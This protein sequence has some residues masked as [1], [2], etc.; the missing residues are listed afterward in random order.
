MR[1]LDEAQLERL[2]NAAKGLGM[3]VLVEVHTEKDLKKVL[4]LPVEII[5]INNRNLNTLK[6]DIRKV[7]KLIPFIPKQMTTVCESGVSSLKDIL[8][9]KGLG[10]NAVLI[11]EAIMKEADVV[12]KMEELNIDG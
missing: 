11:G 9:L 5:G 7:Q 2:L 12:K 6:V 1:I 8:L 4:K 3:E 10:V